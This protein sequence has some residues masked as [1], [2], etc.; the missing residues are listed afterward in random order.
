MTQNLHIWN[1]NADI[2]P[3]HTKP[4]SG[5][6]Y[7]GTSPDPQE[8][9]RMLTKQFGPVGKGFGWTVLEQDYQPL[10]EGVVLHWVRIE[11]WW[12]DNGEHRTY[13]GFG[14]TKAAYM[15]G[16]ADNRYIRTDEDAPK[17][18]LTDAITKAASQ[19]G[20]AANIY[21]GLFD[22][23]RYVTGLE[24]KFRWQEVME[25]DSRFW[26]PVLDEVE[27]DSPDNEIARVAAKHIWSKVEE[28]KT[29]KSVNDYL[30]FNHERFKFVETH[31]PN[32]FTQL[33]DDIVKHRE[34]ITKEAA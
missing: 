9:I 28:Y 12:N 18:S 4:I 22:D 30:K 24:A 29:E 8:I 11:F 5:K 14:Q 7:K 21:L 13:E 2:D 34:K 33:R 20:F 26:D 19:L 3:K 31:N 1:S 27:P 25:N 32:V 16:K 10:G 15:A 6:D 23:N 17:K